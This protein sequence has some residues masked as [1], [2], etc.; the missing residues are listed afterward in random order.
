MAT[1]NLDYV[2]SKKYHFSI[3][4]WPTEEGA[5]TKCNGGR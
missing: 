1:R 3:G 2:S 5:A 4:V